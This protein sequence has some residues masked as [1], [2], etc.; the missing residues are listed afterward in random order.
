M[1]VFENCLPITA[2]KFINKSSLFIILLSGAIR[3]LE[4]KPISE[5]SKEYIR[6]PPYC[7]TFWLYALLINKLS[8]Y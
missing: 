5:K 2:I 1:V 6:R 3:Q 7:Q 4:L 8:G